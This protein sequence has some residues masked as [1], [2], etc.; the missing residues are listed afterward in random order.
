MIK[1]LTVIDIKK[2]NDNLNIKN[3]DGN[4]DSQVNKKHLI[5]TEEK[6]CHTYHKPPYICIYIHIY[7]YIFI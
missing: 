7:I 1:E 2:K 4:F 5:K 3:I 6:P